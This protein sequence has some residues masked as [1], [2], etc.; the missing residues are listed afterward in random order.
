M[1]LHSSSIRD[2]FE[3][4]LFLNY[5]FAISKDVEQSIW[6]A[7]FYRVIEEY[8]RRLRK[9]SSDHCMSE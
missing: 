3:Q 2:N 4:V 1:Y 6:K 9:V 7:V 8:R 5:E